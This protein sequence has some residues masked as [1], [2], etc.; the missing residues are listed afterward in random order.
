M[1]LGGKKND[2]DFILDDILMFPKGQEYE[3]H[4]CGQSRYLFDASS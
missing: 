1:T 3:S 4:Y 2:E